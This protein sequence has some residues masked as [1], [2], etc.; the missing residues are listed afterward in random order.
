[1]GSEECC[2]EDGLDLGHPIKSSC[3]N[4]CRICIMEKNS[5][6][7]Q[8]QCFKNVKIIAGTG[9][10]TELRV[11]GRLAERYGGVASDWSK[12]AG[13]IES[14]KY[15]FDIHWYEKGGKQYEAKLKVRKEKL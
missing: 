12:C 3:T 4:S 2:R 14:G 5:S 1:M 8:I 11:A 6:Y 15:I 10:K 9:S 7:R 13:K